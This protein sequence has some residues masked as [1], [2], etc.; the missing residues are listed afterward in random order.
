MLPDDI[1]NWIASTADVVLPYPA[2]YLSE[3]PGVAKTVLPLA[4]KCFTNV[5]ELG[6]NKC[7]IPDEFS[8]LLFPHLLTNSWKD[9][10]CAKSPP[11]C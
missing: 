6:L 3:L 7:K 4:I 2:Q 10:D 5:V 9:V 1:L 11:L 8:S